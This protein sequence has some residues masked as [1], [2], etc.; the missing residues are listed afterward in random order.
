M[1]LSNVTGR[2]IDNIN[3]QSRIYSALLAS[4]QSQLD[5]LMRSDVAAVDEAVRQLEMHF[6]DRQR[7]EAKRSSLLA[8]AA[9]LI[10]VPLEQIT[11][12]T[13]ADAVDEVMATRLLDSAARLRGLVTE[14]ASIVS[15]SR[16]L[17]EHELAMSV[18]MVRGATRTPRLGAAY[19]R[20]GS[21][22]ESTP[23]AILDAQV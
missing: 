15:S 5:A 9:L 10:G 21:S 20:C 16:A 2:I 17:L 8:E 19:G 1:S 7:A 4:S 11:A 13:L 18:H 12:T 22:I 3:E 23:I 6:V 14:L